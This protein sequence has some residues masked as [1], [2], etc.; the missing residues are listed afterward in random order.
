MGTNILLGGNNSFFYGFVLRNSFYIYVFPTCQ[1]KFYKFLN[2][3]K[4]MNIT[5]MA[6]WRREIK[7]NKLTSFLKDLEIIYY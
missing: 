6:K 4:F 5:I 3:N 2:G 7:I 1:V